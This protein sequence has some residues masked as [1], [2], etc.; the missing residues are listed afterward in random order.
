ME[1]RQRHYKILPSESGLWSVIDSLTGLPAERYGRP[2]T[3]LTWYEAEKAAFN[4]SEST[5]PWIALVRHR[6]R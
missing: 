6:R 2:L 1:R 4:L 3:G 5:P